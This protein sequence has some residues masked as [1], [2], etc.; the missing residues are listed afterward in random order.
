MEG[1]PP[2]PL[3]APAAALALALALV[4]PVPV[5]VGVGPLSRERSFG[6]VEGC[7]TYC[8]SSDHLR[9]LSEVGELR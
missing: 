9:V 5:L 1:A 7:K 4:L 3:L 8:L 6:S 2:L